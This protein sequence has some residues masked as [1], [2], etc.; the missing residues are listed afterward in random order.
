MNKMAYS[1][2]FGVKMSILN[3]FLKIES[4]K[5]ILSRL[6]FIIFLVECAFA[7]FIITG[8]SKLIGAEVLSDLPRDPN[9]ALKLENDI[10]GLR[11]WGPPTQP[12]LSLGRSDIWDR[13]W[14]SDRQPLITMAKIKELAMSDRLSELEKSSNESIYDLYRKYEFPCS[15]SGAQVIL[16]TPFAE[17]VKTRTLSEGTIE[18]TAEGNG[19]KLV[20]L[21]WVSLSRTLVVV[22]CRTENLSANDF[23]L[24]VYRHRDTVLP[25]QKISPTLGGGKASDDFEQLPAPRAF[26]LKTEF[27]VIQDFFPDPTFPKG[28][29]AAV[30]VRVLGT[31]LD[32]V[33][34]ENE[35]GLGTQLW[36]EKE[37]RINHGLLKW[38]T[39]INESPGAAATGLF[40]RIPESFVI[41]CAIATTQDAPDVTSEAARILNEAEKS[42]YAGLLAEQK[43]TSERMRRKEIARVLVDGSVNQEAL[44][45]VYPKLRRSDGYYGDVSLC[46]VG[47][48]KFTFQ[49]VGLWHNDFHF[50]EIRAEGML[51]LGLFPELLPYCEMIHNL[52]PQA[53]ENARDV[54]G[55]PG[56]MYPLAHFPLRCRGVAHTNPAWEQDLGINGLLSKPLWLY[57]RYTGDKEYLRD[58]AYPVL[59]SCAQF[60]RAYLSEES[61]GYLHIFPTVSPEHWGLTP[62]FERNR[63]CLSAITLTRYLFKAAAEAAEILDVDKAEADKWK[64]AAEKLVP[65]PTYQTKDG[66]IWV[67]VAGAP[68][69]EYNIPVPLSAIFWGDDIGLDSPQEKLIIARRTLDNINV[70]IPHRPY[71]NSCVRPRLGIY[72]PDATLGSE[73]FIL[74]YQSIHLFPAVPSDKEIIIKNLCTEGGF[75]ISAVRTKTGIIR[76]VIVQSMLGWQCRLANPWIGKDVEVANEQGKLILKSNEKDHFITFAT[77]K[78]RRYFVQPVN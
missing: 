65:Y 28:F 14:F 67:D 71:L 47:S 57:Y 7:F 4:Y 25:G 23:W 26:N 21:L 59:R 10:V 42:G 41:L 17:K 53:E 3:V 16:G 34:K 70:W 50:N 11:L 49:D 74:S 58:I 62:K 45:L 12:T 51:T 36:A 2:F 30:A 56:A 22:S 9:D 52:L 43:E 68:P 44:P 31:E 15:K 27:G 78:G 63:D 1:K 29:S 75:C 60:C 35:K 61:D 5:E 18:I 20:A 73:N 54:Y 46:S 48:T 24:R 40:Q 64:T 38:Y 66:P 33:C 32:V 8:S 69:I 55:L 19:K 13:R 77:E 37:G 39:P 76:D 6:I 72:Q